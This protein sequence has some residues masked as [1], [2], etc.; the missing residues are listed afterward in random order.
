MRKT[1]LFEILPH[2]NYVGLDFE[3][4]RREAASI[5]SY[6]FAF[7]DGS[8]EGGFMKLHESTPEVTNHFSG[9]TQKQVNSG[10]EFPEFY[11]MMANFAP[12]T[13]FVIHGMKSDRRAFLA[14]QTLFNLPPLKLLWIDALPVAQRHFLQKPSGGGVKEM[15]ALFDMDINHHDPADDAAVSLEVIKRAGGH[16]R[17]LA[18]EGRSFKL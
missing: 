18:D 1:N 6:G 3:F 13:F 12:E 4:G 5:I 7:L 8:R 15:A 17:P 10:I 16:F 9:I 14:S 11:E 2:Y